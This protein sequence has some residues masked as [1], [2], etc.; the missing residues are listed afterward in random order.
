MKRI[1][2][3]GL[4]VMLVVGCVQL[5]ADALNDISKN[6]FGDAR[7]ALDLWQ[8]GFTTESQAATYKTGVEELWKLWY[9]GVAA[10]GVYPL[11]FCDAEQFTLPPADRSLMKDTPDTLKKAYR[12]IMKLTMLGMREN[13]MEMILDQEFSVSVGYR[14][15]LPQMLYVTMFD[16]AESHGLYAEIAMDGDSAYWSILK[17]DIASCNGNTASLLLNKFPSS[18]K[19]YDVDPHLFFGILTMYYEYINNKEYSRY[20]FFQ[21]V[22]SQTNK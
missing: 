18:M 16:K 3:M 17:E 7:M 10:A 4:V 6:T 13:V 20:T 21:Y 22:M 15:F 11:L 14:E 9:V 5:H 12:E 19:V 1:I 8:Y 2:I